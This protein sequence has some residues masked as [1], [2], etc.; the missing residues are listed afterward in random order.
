MDMLR[1]GLDLIIAIQ[2]YRGPWQDAFFRA[3]TFMGEEYFVLLVAPFV[4]WCLDKRLGVRMAFLFLVSSYLN[5]GMKDIFMQPRPFDLDPSVKLWEVTGYGLPSGHAQ[6]AL[7]VCGAVA[8]WQTSPQRRRWAA[9]VAA[10]LAFLIGFSRIYLGV[11]FPTDV[12]TGWTIGLIL[13]AGW[14]R[15][16]QRLEEWLL[17]LTLQRQAVMALGVPLA[18]ILVYPV[19]DNVSALATA[20]GIA[21]GLALAIRYVDIRADGPWPRRLLRFAL[22]I[23]VALLIYAGLKAVFPA[24]GAPP[25]LHFRFVRYV[26]LGLWV[27]VGAPWLFWRLGLAARD[28]AATRPVGAAVS[29]RGM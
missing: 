8:A 5:A 28:T 2:H 10:G 22:G 9:I 12:L 26:L 25:Y 13:L 11:H 3:V 14:L 15:W 24:E 19:A 23:A 20:L 4:Y 21:L 7:L 1:W 29:A 17:G 16:Q 6:T 27:S 18:L